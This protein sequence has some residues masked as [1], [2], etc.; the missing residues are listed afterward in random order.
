MGTFAGYTGKM[1]I[2]EEKRNCFG[3]QMMKILNYGGMMHLEEVSMFDRKLFL[4]SPLELSKQGVVYFWYN[5]FEERNW[6][7]A[8]FNANDL[9][10]Y[11]NK[12]G[13]CEFCEVILA[14]Y[15]LYEMCVETPGFAKCNGE[16][17]NP[18]FYGGWLNHILGTEFSAE[19]RY[20]LWENAEHIAFSRLDYDDPFSMLELDKMISSGFEVAGGTELADLLYIIYGTETLET[21]RIVPGSYPDDVYQCKKALISFREIAGDDFFE[22]LLR[23]LQMDRSK[24]E[25]NTDTTLD[26]LA[27]LSLFLPARVFAYL[28]AE[29]NHKP[30]WELWKEWNDKVYHDEQIKQYASEEL[31]KQRKE[32]RERIIPEIR[33]SEFLRQDGW[34]TFFDTPEELKGKGNYYLS[35]D[36]RIF[37]WDG[38]DEV[39]ISDDMDAWLTELSDR[40]RRLMDLPDAGCGDRFK[41]PDSIED[42]I[43]LLN[44]I[45]DYY[46]RIYPF[47]TMFYDFI[48]NSGKKEYR[49]AL[50]LLE[51]LHEENKEEGKV[52]RY[53]KEEWGWEMNSKNVTQ[54]IARLRLKRYLSVMANVKIRKK[55]FDF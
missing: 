33:T 29:I 34:F 7:R 55:Y 52:I 10:F 16:L 53:A 42:F 47:K 18:W 22:H 48:Q 44:E 35:D 25:K 38:T 8:G 27:E 39:I 51:M 36:D 41:G 15:M 11:S 28:A 37:W 46:R 12:I 1:D 54:N 26:L 50:A 6:V 9:T 49:A 2:P 32:G 40:H 5:Y 4:L 13:T 43:I 45:C 17:L 21:D 30:F 20:N 24:R 3:K 23:F 19:K 14:V 31:Q